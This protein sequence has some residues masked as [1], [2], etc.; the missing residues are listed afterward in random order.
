MLEKNAFLEADRSFKGCP[1]LTGSNTEQTRVLT[2]FVQKLAE[3]A[4][5]SAAT[6]CVDFIVRHLA[7]DVLD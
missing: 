4:R 1:P 3:E 5:A 2:D 6:R 7:A